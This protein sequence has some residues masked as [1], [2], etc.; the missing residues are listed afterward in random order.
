MLRLLGIEPRAFLALTRAFIIMDLRGQHY[1]AATASKHVYALTPLFIVVG[2][3]LVLSMLT[4]GFLYARADVFLFV[5]VN[6]TLSLLMTAS[7]VVVEFQEA[8]LNPADLMVIGHRPVPPRTYAAARLANLLF[9]FALMFLALNIVPAVCGATLRDAGPWFAP[10]YLAA[11]L[12]GGLAT[13]AVVVI[14]LTVVPDGP[15]L[16]SVKAVLSW[17]QIVLIMVVFYGGQLLLRGG[18]SSLLVWGAFPPDWVEQTPPAWLARFVERASYTPDTSAVY[19]FLILFGVGVV[20]LLAAGLRLASVYATLQPVEHSAGAARPMPAGRLGGLPGGWLAGGPEAR[21]GYWLAVTFLRR[22]PA[23]GLRCLFG[24]QLA[25]VAAAVGI[26]TGQLA[27]PMAGP[28][29]AR[30]MLTLLAFFVLPM[31]APSLVYNIAYS[32]DSAGGWL[33]RSAP[34]ADPLALAEGACKAVML[35]VVTPLCIALGVAAGI[36]WGSPLSG[37]LHAVYAWGLTWAFILASLWLV[38]PALPFSLPQARGAGLALP[39]LPLLGLGTTAGALAVLH[40]LCARYPLYWVAVLAAVP[41]AWV[42]LRRRAGVW[43]LR[44]G[45]AE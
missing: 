31:G 32:K 36:A 33:L 27:D 41:L 29:P 39:P 15:Y 30:G 9:Y 10:A 11:A 23:L 28:D 16:Q 4:C 1:A 38:S 8:A 5:L 18:F 7:A 42:L 22:D 12:A 24:F 35:W 17:V 6:L 44:L 2:Q 37:T 13:V 26:A 21:A 43:M 25:A 19:C 20:A 34:V 40:Q 14:L 3:L 45:G